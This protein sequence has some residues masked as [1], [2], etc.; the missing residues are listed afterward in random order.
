MFSSFTIQLFNPPDEIGHI[1]SLGG[2]GPVSAAKMYGVRTTSIAYFS[3]KKGH[4][5]NP[6]E[7]R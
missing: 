4:P 5:F 3:F 2:F 7:L 1:A 6:K